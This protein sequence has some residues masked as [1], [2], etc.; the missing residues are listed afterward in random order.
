MND[1]DL[2]ITVLVTARIAMLNDETVTV[3]SGW[4]RAEIGAD[5]GFEHYWYAME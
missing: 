4:H 1:S 3:Y 2:A 5:D